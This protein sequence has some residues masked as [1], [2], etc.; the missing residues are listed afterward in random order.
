MF[1][2]VTIRID[3]NVRD[4]CYRP[5][6]GHSKGCPNF[7]K[8]KSCPPQCSIVEY[9][10]NLECSTYAIWNIFD[11]A[12]HMERMKR[13]HPGWS[14]WQ[15]ICCLYWQPKARKA[16]NEEIEKFRLIYPDLTVIK[17]PE[18]MGINV[19]KTMEGIGEILEWPPLIKTYQIAIAGMS[20]GC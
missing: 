3:H 1:K 4:L 17:C 14:H 16:L 5:Y 6:R 13:L 8:R 12:E 18:A 20:T 9:I 15:L 19:T 11:L 2:E 10:I 7:G